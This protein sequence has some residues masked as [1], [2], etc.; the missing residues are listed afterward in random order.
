MIFRERM[1][2]M[3]HR[4]RVR[5]ALNHKRNRDAESTRQRIKESTENTMDGIHTFQEFMLHTKN[6][7]Y[8][9]IILILLAMPAIWR[10][11]AGHDDE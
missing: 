5:T 7:V 11:L 3:T 9:I 4:E 1:Y 10:F 8:I 2:Q 6:I